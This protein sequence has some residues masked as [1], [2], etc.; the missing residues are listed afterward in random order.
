MSRT[1]QESLFWGF[2]LLVIGVLFMLKNFGIRIDIWHIIGTYWPLLLIAI[3]L[4]NI[5]YHF[6]LKNK[7]E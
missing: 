4:K 6:T 2:I 5:L 3:G 1:K 7:Q